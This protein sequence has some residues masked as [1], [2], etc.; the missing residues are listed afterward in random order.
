MAQLFVDKY[1]EEMRGVPL[2]YNLGEFH[3]ESLYLDN[4]GT[5]TDISTVF[6]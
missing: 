4:N 2:T 5:K 1:K 6:G 3:G